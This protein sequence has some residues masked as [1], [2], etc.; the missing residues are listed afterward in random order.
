VGWEIVAVGF[1]FFPVIVCVGLCILL[2]FRDAK[3]KLVLPNWHNN[4]FNFSQPEQFCHLAGFS[5]LATGAGLAI[6]ALWGA[7]GGFVNAFAA[8]AFGAGMLLGLQILG[9]VAKWQA[10]R[11]VW[12]QN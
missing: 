8:A 11:D 7:G 12:G 5:M 10:R 4:P 6:A 3:L 1:L 2:P 9:S